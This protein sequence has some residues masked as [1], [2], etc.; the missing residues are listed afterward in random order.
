[1]KNKC[2]KCGIKN[3]PLCCYHLHH[4]D[5]ETKVFSVMSKLNENRLFKDGWEI[6]QQEI[7]KCELLCIHCHK[8]YHLGDERAQ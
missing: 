7:D 4:T 2:Q 6:I 3:L 8:I 1:M 5:P